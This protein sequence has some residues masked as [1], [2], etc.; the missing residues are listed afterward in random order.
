VECSA[1]LR[2]S[3]RGVREVFSHASLRRLL[4]LGWLIPMFSVAPKP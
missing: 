2:D 4:I 1:L 3:L